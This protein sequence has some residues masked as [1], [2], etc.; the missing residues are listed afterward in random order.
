MIIYDGNNQ[1]RI[2][3]ETE[4]R[5][6]RTMQFL[7]NL[8]SE[9]VI[10]TWDGFGS[11]K[12]RRDIFPGYK[13]KKPSEKAP[14][15]F[16]LTIKEIKRMLRHTGALQIECEGYEADDVI[17][18]VVAG[19]SRNERCHIMSTD[20][21][22]QVLKLIPNVTTSQTPLPDVA[23]S[24]MQL[25]KACVGDSSDK[26][27]GIPGFGKKAWEDVDRVSLKMFVEGTT[28][29]FPHGLS[30]RVHNWLLD[31]ENVKLLRSMYK[32]IEL[33]DV[34]EP[35]LVAGMKVGLRADAAADA[36]MK[37]FLQ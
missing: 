37:E 35:L 31:Q 34:P 13:I 12:R 30:K 27:P 8:T 1:A 17:A 19:W 9:P 33:I 26:I 28:K 21:D 3:W 4:S 15:D 14:S 11:N 32:C 18:S 25:Y 7:S 23:L 29:D 5:P 20:R 6:M 16:F 2:M 10:W 24:D 22:L 36:I